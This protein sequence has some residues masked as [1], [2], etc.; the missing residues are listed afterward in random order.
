MSGIRNPLAG[1]DTEPSRLLRFI[2]IVGVFLIVGP[3]VGGLTFWLSVRALS[4]L[5]RPDLPPYSVEW[6]V[7]SI[8]FAYP[9]G[10]PFAFAAGIF[11]AV[12]AIWWRWR[13]V[14][15][16]LA[17]GGTISVIGSAVSSLLHPRWDTLAG[18]F[19]AGLL[20]TLPTSVVASLICWRLTRSLL[21]MA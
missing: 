19:L 2:G 7:I 15:L 20:L 1:A 8:L 9:L 17:A 6:L 21:S 10:A 3:A 4:G 13:N 16:P 18:E 5:W 12:A 14:W 11:H